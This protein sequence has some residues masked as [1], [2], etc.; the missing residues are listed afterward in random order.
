MDPLN[1]DI[2]PKPSLWR[3]VAKAMIGLLFTAF[4]LMGTCGGFFAV[5]DLRGPKPF[6][7]EYVGLLPYFSLAIGGVCAWGCYRLFKHLGR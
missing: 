5:L 7:A 6:H 4:A 1:I 2:T 3:L